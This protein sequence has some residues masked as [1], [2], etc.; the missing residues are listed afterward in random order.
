MKA[1]AVGLFLVLSA[2]NLNSQTDKAAQLVIEGRKVVVELIKALATKKDSQVNA[3]CKNAYANLCILN[4]SNTSIIADLQHRGSEEK[5]EMIIPKTTKECSLH[6]PIVV[7]T[8]ELRLQ[9][10]L[11]PIRKGDIL[12]ESCQNLTMNIKY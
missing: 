2:F 9:E 10:D 8:Y 12:I 1:V 4:E 3:P 7:W 11:Y 5:R 6:V